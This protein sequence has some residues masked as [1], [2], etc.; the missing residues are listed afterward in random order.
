[1]IAAASHVVSPFFLTRD[2]ATPAARVFRS[3]TYLLSLAIPCALELRPKS[4]S[5]TVSWASLTPCSV[6][7]FRNFIDLLFVSAFPSHSLVRVEAEEVLTIARVL[8]G[9]VCVVLAIHLLNGSFSGSFEHSSTAFWAE[10]LV[11][12]RWFAESMSESSDA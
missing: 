9:L 8:K 4:L 6:I 2:R 5:K 1:M 11:R 12:A 3:L 10:N 7:S